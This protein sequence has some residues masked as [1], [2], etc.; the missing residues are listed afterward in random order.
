MT[1]ALV[2]IVLKLHKKIYDIFLKRKP[3]VPEDMKARI[4]SYPEYAENVD[5]LDLNYVKFVN[6]LAVRFQQITGIDL[7]EMEEVD[8]ETLKKIFEEIKRLRKGWL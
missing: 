8:N 5:K 3:N 7:I 2:E 4:L 1:D 6:E